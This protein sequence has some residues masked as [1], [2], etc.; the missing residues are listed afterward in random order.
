MAIKTTRVIT[1]MVIKASGDLRTD[2][3]PT[4]RTPEEGDEEEVNA[5]TTTTMTTHKPKKAQISTSASLPLPSRQVNPPFDLSIP[6]PEIPVRGRL[7]Y[8]KNQWN[9]LTKDPIVIQMISGC[10][11]EVLNTLPVNNSV[12]EIKMSQMEMSIALDHIQE[13][14]HKHIIIPSHREDGDFCSNVFLCPKS[15]GKYRMILNLKNF[16]II[17]LRN[18][19]S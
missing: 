2:A 16:S 13:L 1:R 12:R 15:N 3:N 6:K 7:K 8:F 19:P 9:N 17:L 18:H 4:P 11:I 10:P 5:K 14:L